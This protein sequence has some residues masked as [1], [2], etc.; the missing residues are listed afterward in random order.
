MSTFILRHLIWSLLK[1]IRTPYLILILLCTVSVH[2]LFSQQSNLS[3]NEITPWVNTPFALTESNTATALSGWVNT[4]NVINS[5]LSDFATATILVSGT[6]TL[7]VSDATNDYD[8]GNFA[9]F[10]IQSGLLN[11]GIFDGISINTYLDGTLQET[12]NA[13]DLVTLDLSLFG[14]PFEVG[15]ITT[16]SFDEVELVIANPLGVITSVDVYYSSLEGFCVGP[17]LDCN[18]QTALNNADFPTIV[19]YG[20]T[21]A[22][23]VTIGNVGT[24]QDAVSADTSDFASLNNLI[25]A[26]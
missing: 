23:G 9:G 25:G 21:G 4:G 3:C 1:L 26:I 8:A 22:D 16:T 19:D 7:K 5:N 14:S 24:P 18:T 12:Y 13:I 2:P 15:F 20:N 6:V 17:P 10:L 11:A